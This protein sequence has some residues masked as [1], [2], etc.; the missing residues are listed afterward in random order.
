MSCKSTPGNENKGIG[1]PIV[2]LL[3]SFGV[4][5]KNS[6]NTNKF[7][8]SNYLLRKIKDLTRTLNELVTSVN[9]H[10]ALTNERKTDSTDG[11]K[12]ETQNQSGTCV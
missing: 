11:R 12:T 1:E 7:A 9:I 2:G 3:N 6:N 8:N 4:I 5:K 10:Y